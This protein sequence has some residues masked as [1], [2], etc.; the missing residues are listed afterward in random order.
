[1][2][3]LEW[4]QGFIQRKFAV[5][6]QN[7]ETVFPIW[8]IGIDDLKRENIKTILELVKNKIGYTDEDLESIQPLNMIWKKDTK[9][10]RI[11]LIKL[12]RACTRSPKLDIGD[13]T[14]IGFQWCNLNEAQICCNNV[15]YRQIL[16]TAD[17]IIHPD[18]STSH[19]ICT[20][21]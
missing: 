5:Q 20:I 8:T 3:Y 6:S 19:S 9:E 21:Q 10:V 18:R 17:R 2:A 16:A 7:F 15:T 13:G 4:N 1:M 12:N 11:Y 14:I